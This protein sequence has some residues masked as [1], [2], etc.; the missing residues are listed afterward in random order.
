ML[1]ARISLR[2]SQTFNNLDSWGY[3]A[4][5]NI[6]MD[7][8]VF[9]WVLWSSFYRLMKRQTRL[10][11]SNIANFILFCF[12][13]NFDFGV[14]WEYFLLALCWCLPHRLFIDK[15]RGTNS[16][17][18]IAWLAKNWGHHGFWLS[19]SNHFKIDHSM[20]LLSVL[21][22]SLQPSDRPQLCEPSVVALYLFYDW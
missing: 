15:E 12:Q 18:V 6:S 2:S 9:F 5:L 10:S 13:K 14:L 21:A 8:M 7:L 20:K 3:M 22:T 19:Q 11:P 4:I 17:N 1:N 16:I